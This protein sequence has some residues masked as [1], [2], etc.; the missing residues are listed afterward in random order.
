MRNAIIFYLFVI[1]FVSSGIA[2]ANMITFDGSV[3]GSGEL[4]SVDYQYFNIDMDDLITIETS[5][6]NFDP[7]IY[8][9]HDDGFLDSNDFIESDD[10]SS[11]PSAFG[12]FN[13][14]IRRSLT[15]G[16]YLVAV[17]DFNFT[18][19]EAVSGINDSSF[20]GVGSG[21]YQL[22]VSADRAT[23]TATVPEPASLI[24][25]GLGLIG[26]AA[27]SRKKR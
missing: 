9:F 1:L 22:M 5:T 15:A 7:F 18:L 25:L 21:A 20:Y 16:D 10:D 8:L 2:G 14:L 13:S 26:L 11:I 17:A 23:V 6:D 12:F 27:V 4:G 19:D 3:A 24:I